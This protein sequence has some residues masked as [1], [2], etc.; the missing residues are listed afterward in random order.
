MDMVVKEEKKQKVGTWQVRCVRE[1][2]WEKL[3]KK[4]VGVLNN[5]WSW[6]VWEK[7]KMIGVLNNGWSG[8]YTCTQLLRAI[9]KQ[10]QKY[11]LSAW[12]GNMFSYF[13]LKLK[14]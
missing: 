3:K 4:V 14:K 1:L 12:I 13:T 8:K 9:L 7:Q 5:F 10:I 6:D 2:I 11:Y